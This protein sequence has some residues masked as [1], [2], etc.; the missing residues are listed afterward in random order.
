MK[1]ND[2]I[3]TGALKVCNDN[4]MKSIPDII[5]PHNFSS[6]FERKMER[7]IRAHRS[8]HG[9]LKIERMIRY[10]TRL[11][12]VVICFVLINVL[13][14][15]AFNY[16]LWE[17]AYQKVG[18][19]INI[20]FI[21]N[22]TDNTVVETDTRLKIAS[23]PTGYE[24]QEEYFS[25]NLSVQNFKGE[26]GTITYTEGLITETADVNITVKKGKSE[27][28]KIM[29]G[30]KEI[31]LAYGDDNITAFFKDNKYYHIIEVQGADANE[32]FVTDIIQKLEAQ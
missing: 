11:A 32:A 26:K 15:N 2:D 22:E 14:I 31:T 20:G 21:S 10:T 28:N 17:T 13:S 27:T 8:F 29:V 4:A 9:S 16:N 3:L 7:I 30:A 23:L 12:G 1:L 5:D 24:K 19:M 25:N 18:E 6:K